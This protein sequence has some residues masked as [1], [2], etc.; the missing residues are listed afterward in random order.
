[1]VIK[2]LSGIGR[3]VVNSLLQD[4]LLFL[5]S[6]QETSPRPIVHGESCSFIYYTYYS[7][8]DLEVLIYYRSELHAWFMYM[9]YY[10]IIHRGKT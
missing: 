7:I 9:T 10:N 3:C 2:V 4:Q 5:S 1:M 6:G 8:S